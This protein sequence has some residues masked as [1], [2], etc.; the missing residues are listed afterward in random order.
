MI[1]PGVWASSS[2]LL[3]GVLNGLAIAELDALD[4]L[5]QA[6]GTVEPAPVVLGRLRELEDHG[7]TG[8]A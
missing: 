7:E 4:A 3:F 2:G 8:L 6:A 1:N 5:A